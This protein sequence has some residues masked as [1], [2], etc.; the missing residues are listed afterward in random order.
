MAGNMQIE[1]PPWPQ[2]ALF[3]AAVLVVSAFV[4]TA[5][6]QFPREHRKPGLAS[7]AGT[8]ILWLTIL[9]VSAAG[10][11]AMVFAWVVLPWYTVVIGA[12]LMILIAPYVLHPLP[13]WFINGRSLL[14]VLCA[15]AVV[16][17]AGMWWTA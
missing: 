5:A 9:A 6:G 11:A 10:I 14:V 15:V 2:F 1:L 12:G 17:V 8:I 4:I 13:D 7:P 3:M 16:L